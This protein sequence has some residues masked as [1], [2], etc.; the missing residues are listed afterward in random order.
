MLAY[1]R[2]YLALANGGNNVDVVTISPMQVTTP[3]ADT[4]DQVFSQFTATDN[5]LWH[6]KLQL[7]TAK[8]AVLE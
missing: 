2:A 6:T 8:P 7:W 4:Y 3:F 5:P 1:A